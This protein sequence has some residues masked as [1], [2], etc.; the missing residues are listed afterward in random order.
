MAKLSLLRSLCL[1]LFL[2][3]GLSTFSVFHPPHVIAPSFLRQSPTR[4]VY[5]FSSFFFGNS[6]FPIRR[7]SCNTRR[8]RKVVSE[9]STNVILLLLF[10]STA[11]GAGRR[12]AGTSAAPNSL[13]SGHLFAS[14]LLSRAE[15][16]RERLKGSQETT[17]LALAALDSVNSLAAQNR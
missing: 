9:A 13:L 14:F 11:R 5:I 6:S 1:S 4:R 10:A 15:R 12:A 2:C 16:E 7:V 3:L 8:T 17:R